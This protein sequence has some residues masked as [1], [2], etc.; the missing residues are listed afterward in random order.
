MHSPT[1]YRPLWLSLLTRFASAKSAMA[2]RV[3]VLGSIA[4][5]A[6]QIERDYTFGFF[7]ADS[8]TNAIDEQNPLGEPIGC[9]SH[10]Q[11]YV[12]GGITT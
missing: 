6:Q 12:L 4:P 5:L 1:A 11:G 3:R 8:G 10:G 2:L 7:V 9:L